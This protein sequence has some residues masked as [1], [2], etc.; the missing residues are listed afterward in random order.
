M[1][2]IANNI[3]LIL[4]VMAVVGTMAGFLSGIFGIGGGIILVPA[5]LYM[6][7]FLGYDEI[8]AM[9]LA[10]ATSLA[11]SVF[12]TFSSF[13]SH[14][15]RENVDTDLLKSWGP[16]I[17]I[18]VGIGAYIGTLVEGLVLLKVF[19]IY[20]VL[21][22]FAMVRCKETK[23]LFRDLPGEPW[24]GITGVVIGSLSSMLGIGG[25]TITVPKMALFGKPMK[26]AVG[27]AA[28][29]SAMIC[30][31]G[32]ISHIISG[33]IAGVSIPYSIGYVNWA[34][35]VIVSPIGI[36]AARLGAMVAQKADANRL[37]QFFAIFL[38]FIGVR[39]FYDAFQLTAYYDDVHIF[40]QQSLGF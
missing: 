2:P 31:T 39:M 20:L 27:T 3:E 34:A 25:G 1:D 38:V 28:A 24:R 8:T 33:L 23:P 35:F 26:E 9:H 7:D 10:V 19:A 5:F 30:T 12:A 36:F 17:L 15:K 6:F 11:V 4:T 40:V 32:A 16:T 22:A 18:G 13:R 21:A 14:L 37:R 29:L